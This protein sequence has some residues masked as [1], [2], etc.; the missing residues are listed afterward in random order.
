MT[1]LRRTDR[2]PYIRGPGHC[3]NLPGSLR[4]AEE[5]IGIPMLSQLQGGLPPASPGVH[6]YI[7]DSSVPNALMFWDAAG[8]IYR[9]AGRRVLTGDKTYYVSPAGS[10]TTG[11]GSASKPWRNIWYAWLWLSKNIDLGGNCLT[12]KLA[13][14]TYVGGFSCYGTVD[15]PPYDQYFNN[16]WPLGL[17][18]IRVTGDVDAPQNYIVV[19]DAK[20]NWSCFEAALNPSIFTTIEGVWLKG[21]PGYAYAT[22]FNGDRASGSLYKCIIGEVGGDPF[23]YGAYWSFGN[24]FTNNCEWRGSFE[25][26]RASCRERVSSPV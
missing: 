14:G 22:A 12:I 6:A 10:D 24:C 17:G 25:I 26:G 4:D 7:D 8:Q 2:V 5:L 11:D 18:T 1:D 3:P 16:V 13:P 15:T 21:M 19:A 9:S 23:G 20:T